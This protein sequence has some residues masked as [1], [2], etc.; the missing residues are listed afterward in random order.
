MYRPGLRPEDMAPWGQKYQDS[1]KGV[2]LQD[3]K[4]AKV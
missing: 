4:V 2:T 1:V 3:A